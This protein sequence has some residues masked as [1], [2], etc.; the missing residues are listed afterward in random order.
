[1]KCIR[2][3]TA[4]MLVLSLFAVT[5]CLNSTDV[6]IGVIIPEEGSLANYGYQIR[7]GIQ[8]AN[9][10]IKAD[11]DLKKNYELIFE[12]E[13]E[14]DIE[15]IRASFMRL[16]EKG[17]TAI[18]GAAS[19]AGT[20][21]LVDLANEHGI[22]LLSPASSSPD[23]NSG[24]SDFV[25]RNYPSDTLE[26]QKLSN[27]IFQKC[28]MQ[29][30]LM[31]RAKNT[32]SEG[33]TYELLRFGRQ[34]S[35][36][37]P[38][39]VVKFDADPTK[40]D[41]KARVDEIVEVMPEGVFLAAYTDELIP[42]IRE[43]KSRPELDQTYL[44]TC[45]ALVINDLVEQ[46]GVELVEGLMFTAYDWD[47]TST[48][49]KIQEFTKEFQENYHTTPGV[50]AATGYDA[51]FILVNSIDGVNHGIKDE[52][53]DFINKNSHPGIL[54]ETDFNKGGNVTRIPKVF[55]IEN[56]VKVVLTR[57]NMEIIRRDI[58]TRL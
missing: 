52:L 1:M 57:E 31:V 33:I 29:N 6:K 24:Q 42:L 10:K 36:S 55:R 26:A 45:S 4:A 40:V 51:L 38:P 53:T 15:G 46:L 22:V 21:A 41:F 49:P 23:I 11:A 32:F 3:M 58:L 43:I 47:P 34:N 50:F 39:K 44:F 25:Y 2:L 16:Q 17:V 30:V 37:I 56:G 14:N 7:S 13:N 9:D 27:V 18:I 12:N 5:S 48:D 8:M 19:S 20:L 54:G 35:K 28:R